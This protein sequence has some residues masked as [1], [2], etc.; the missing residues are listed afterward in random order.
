MRRSLSHR[1]RGIKGAGTSTLKKI[2]HSH[3]EISSDQPNDECVDPNGLAD[4]P[5]VNEIM[6]SAQPDT[7]ENVP[8]DFWDRAEQTLRD[9]SD[10]QTR[11]V[12]ETYLAILESELGATIAVVASDRQKQLSEFT[13]NRINDLDD[14]K[15][16]IQFRKNHVSVE[17][18]FA[19]IVKNILAVKEIVST[20]ASADPH[21]ALACAGVTLILSLLI[22]SI[23]EHKFLLAGFEY[24]SK[25]ICQFNVIEKIYMSRKDVVLGKV[26]DAVR[27]GIEF[28][29]SMLD[30]YSGVLEF[31][32]RTLCHL[33]RHSI[34][35]TFKET[36]E[37]NSWKERLDSIKESETLCRNFTSIIDSAKL[38]SGME[39]QEQHLLE[40]RRDTSDILRS[41]GMQGPQ[42]AAARNDFLKALYTSRYE[43]HKDRN[44]EAAHGT[45]QWFVDHPLFQ[46]WRDSSSSCFLWVSADPGCG[47]SVLARR[48]IDHAIPKSKMRH[49][50]YFFFKDDQ[51]EQKSALNALSAML[52][53]LFLQNDKLVT[54]SMLEDFERDPGWL[55]KSFSSLWELLLK[56][57]NDSDAGEIVCVLDALDECAEAERS[58]LTQ[59]LNKFYRME[60]S[61]SRLKFLVTS[62]PYA[63]IQ[64]DFQPLKNRAPE[65]HLSGEDDIETEK[66]SREINLVIHT[67]VE[68]MGDRLQL[69]HDERAFLRNQLLLIPHRTYLWVTLIFDVIENSISYTN[70]K[71]QEIIRTLP[72]T[73]D[74]AYERILNQSPDQTKARRLLHIV[75]SA[76]RPLTLKEMRIALAIRPSDR[77][78]EDLDLESETRFPA[79]V[80]NLCGL[81]V[82]IIDSKIYLLHQTA[83][84]F[85]VYR[86][87]D[88]SAPLAERRRSA[89]SDRR[90]Q[91]EMTPHWKHSLIPTE[92]NNIM[93]DICI[94]YLLF[95]NFES[96]PPQDLET[97]ARG[98]V[99]LEYAA[100]NWAEHYRNAAAVK[101]LATLESVVEICRLGSKRF[102]LWFSIYRRGPN[103]TTRDDQESVEYDHSETRHWTDSDFSDLLLASHFGLDLRVNALL[104]TADQDLDYKGSW[105]D[106]SALTVAAKNGHEAIVKRLLNAGA[107]GKEYD[108]EYGSYK[109]LEEAAANGHLQIVK[110]LFDWEP[111]SIYSRGN[112]KSTAFWQA[113]KNGHEEVVRLLLAAGADVKGANDVSEDKSPLLAAAEHGHLEIVSLLLKQT[114]IDPTWRSATG[115]T[116]LS[117]AASG[118]HHTLVKLLLCVEGVDPNCRNKEGHSPLSLAAVGGHI[119]VIKLLIATNAVQHDTKDSVKYRTPLLWSLAGGHGSISKLLLE[120][121]AQDVECRDISSACRTALS[122]AAGQGNETLVDLLLEANANPNSKS[123]HSRTPLSYACETGTVGIAQRLLDTK[124]VGPDL[125]DTAYSRTPLSWAAGAGQS[126]IVRL[127]LRLPGVDVI[128]RD[129]MYGRTPRAWALAQKHGEIAHMIREEEIRRTGDT[130]E[131]MVVPEHGDDH[132]GS[133]STSTTS[134]TVPALVVND[135]DT[136]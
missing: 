12:M 110:V 5:H 10:S 1:F 44:Q 66:I 129:S 49:I 80:R 54:K 121:G 38:H 99:F 85:L 63:H 128:S 127:L 2:L 81:F 70:A 119:E 40:V 131:Q 71:V 19:G 76:I 25:L 97:L 7:S 95:E 104:D 55:T 134:W 9:S 135:V 77:T 83:K 101:Q 18:I 26:E 43:D 78:H 36:F 21:A 115:S 69:D 123:T 58:Q 116:S 56:V 6:L 23:N 34:A 14:K 51:V 31:Q 87:G 124:G 65:I 30:L 45:C 120:H 100:K 133:K 60:H 8:T 96:S 89:K 15:W 33:R 57:T 102:D 74:E 82:T 92:S 91:N 111:E 32:A 94:T 106:E 22:R 88:P 126:D 13:R 136:E 114:G 107:G 105:F 16:K 62:R 130:L 103:D 61:K 108:V 59:A 122:I 112:S 37:V 73:V 67:R 42:A 17:S 117:L 64:R 125:A 132:D 52:R 24:T 3:P 53:Q 79:V 118:G 72:G 48:L 27:F 47:K 41:L 109:P 20:A 46:R 35:Q 50:C 84:D 93:T 113:A 90:P 75:V 39:K 28:E 98:R 86:A 68:E 11:K 29:A 4:S